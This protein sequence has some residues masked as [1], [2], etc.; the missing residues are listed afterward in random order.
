MV[1]TKYSMVFNNRHPYPDYVKDSLFDSVSIYD[2]RDT[3]FME[4]SIREKFVKWK[5]EGFSGVFL[6]LSGLISATVSAINVAY[7]EHLY[8]RLYHYSVLTDSWL[9]QNI[10]V[11]DGVNG[12]ANKLTMTEE[13]NLAL[14][15]QRTSS[16]G[17]YAVSLLANYVLAYK[18]LERKNLHTVLDWD[19]ER[20]VL[21]GR[22]SP[23]IP[24]YVEAMR[25][26]ANRFQ[27]DPSESYSDYLYKQLIQ[28]KEGP[29]GNGGLQGTASESRGY[30]TARSVSGKHSRPA[31]K[32]RKRR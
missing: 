13:I 16:L 20:A 9:P 22:L 28:R 17:K 21:K 29:Y 1:L 10:S 6:F 14:E 32:S 27:Q 3:K 18:E 4:A 8:L 31:G 23:Y 30:T 25:I 15:L 26:Y 19:A 2:P 5:S 7:E 24:P 11:F 12:Y